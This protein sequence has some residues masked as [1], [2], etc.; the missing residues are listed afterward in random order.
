MNDSPDSPKAVSDDGVHFEERGLAASCPRCQVPLS[1]GH[2]AAFKI[3]CCGRCQGI[4]AQR[5][6]FSDLVQSLRA[7]Y[8]GPDARPTPLQAEEL[9][10][11]CVCSVCATKMETHAYGGPGN[12]VIDSCNGCGLIWLDRNELNK[13]KQAPG[14]R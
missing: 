3:G 4:L 1:V 8:Q 2:V 13:I 5:D 7:E 12:V 9:E 11:S 6:I 14:R 10:K